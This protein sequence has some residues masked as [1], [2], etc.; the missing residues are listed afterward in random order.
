MFVLRM[1]ATESMD[2]LEGEEGDAKQ[3]RGFVIS[4]RLQEDCGSG[5]EPADVRWKKARP[6]REKVCD[7]TGGSVEAASE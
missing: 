2:P 7:S 3:S 1:S 4:S 6:D 5:L